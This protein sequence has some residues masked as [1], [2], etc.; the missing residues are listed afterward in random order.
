M[1]DSSKPSMNN[2]EDYYKNPIIES[3]TYVSIGVDNLKAED[4]PFYDKINKRQAVLIPEIEERL[5]DISLASKELGLD[6]TETKSY[7]R[8]FLQKFPFGIK[9]QIG[10]DD[11]NFIF[12]YILTKISKPK[13]IIETGS[14]VGFSS[15]IIALAV[16]ENNNGCKFY[17]IDPYPGY[18]WEKV[19]F[20]EH[21]K[22]RDPKI[23]HKNLDGECKPLGMVPSDLREHIIFKSGRSEDI[24]PGLLRENGGI[25][26]FFHDSDHS[27]RNMVWECSEVTPYLKEG[28]YILVH[29]VAVNSSFKK[30]FDAEAG[31]VSFSISGRRRSN[32]GIFHKT[33][34]DF[35]L[36]EKWS[37]SSDNSRLNDKE[38]ES[39]NTRLLSSPKEIVIHLTGRCGLNCAF[40]GG[41]KNNREN[42]FDYFLRQS[43]SRLSRYISQAEKIVF[44]GCGTLFDSAEFKRM[45]SWRCNSLEESFPESEKVYYTNGLDLTPEVCDFIINPR[46]IIYWRYKVKT[47]LNIILNAS[48]SNLYKT[49]TGSGD[50]YRILGQIRYLIKLR[51]ANIEP[52]FHRC[53]IN[54]LFM[55]TALN[56]DDLP[57]FIALCANLG[58]DKVISFYSHIY[59]P[60]QN[61]LSCFFKQE[62][63]NRILEKAEKLA[64][65]LKV[66]LDL[67]PKF[68]QREYPETGIC[69]KAW[70]LINLDAKGN[71]L[72]CGSSEECEDGLEG[73]T[74][75]VWNGSYY[76]NKRE[77]LIKGDSSCFKYCIRANPQAV[78]DLNSHMVKNPNK[79]ARAGIL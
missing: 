50:F 14:N 10:W 69:D 2:L 66:K 38:F 13:L 77:S 18:P 11:V 48:N 46:G 31:G 62:T 15:A 63:T 27:Y 26:I 5:R 33:N 36:K 58:A 16:K 72:A 32:L 17:T 53:E 24:L 76:R 52:S 39:R 20:V 25:D 54:L 61:H 68:A 41:Q 45:I 42:D 70:S 43:E 56:I 35:T 21:H 73:E 49:L 51:E 22:M 19:S 47:T 67:P 40:C 78:N 65:E 3:W 55:A 9:K 1:E 74:M 23:D 8:E 4:P 28:G 57:D 37:L 64:K 60:G 12:L 44:K 29:D 34:K 6:Y 7:V 30:M 79:I 59:E 71:V 75:D